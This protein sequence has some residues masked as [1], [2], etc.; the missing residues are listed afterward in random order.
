M[1]VVHGEG[2]ARLADVE[3]GGPGPLVSG[4]I[5]Q[6][7]A[8]LTIDAFLIGEHH[9]PGALTERVREGRFMDTFQPTDMGYRVQDVLTALAYLRSRRDM[10]GT[11]DLVGLGD[12]GVWC[13]FAGAIDGGVR[14]T[15]V[16]A[17]G[18]DADNDAAWIARHYAPCIRSV[19]DID[20]AAALLAPKRLAIWD[21]PDSFA[22]GIRDRY[23][24]IEPGALR[25]ER[26]APTVVAMLDALQGTPR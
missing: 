21:A 10:T 7:K 1:V 23:A 15:L 18:F 6:G 14:N 20:T 19:G 12:G 26:E 11:V 13:L 22:D 4:L 24:A 9:A 3:H 2:K 17:N 16:D 25:I 8:V 5:A